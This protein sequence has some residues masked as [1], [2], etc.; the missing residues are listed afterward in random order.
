MAFERYKASWIERNGSRISPDRSPP[1]LVT[2][3]WI[4]IGWTRE[5]G[6]FMRLLCFSSFRGKRSLSLSL[7]ATAFVASLFVS[8][9]LLPPSSSHSLALLPRLES[10]A[11]AATN[12]RGVNPRELPGLRS[13][14]ASLMIAP[15][16]ALPFCLALS[17]SSPPRPTLPLP[18]ALP[19]R[20]SL[21]PLSPAL[22]PR[23]LA[24]WERVSRPKAS[25]KRA[26]VRSFARLLLLAAFWV[27][28]VRWQTKLFRFKKGLRIIGSF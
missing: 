9:S 7:S 24:A 6:N 16:R 5:P 8:R 10:H 20:A 17:P 18:S 14:A 12:V 23:S 26:C 15:S 2:R 19:P 25:G 11:Y 1:R 3:N 4:R 21:F 27:D 28:V 22:R 13:V